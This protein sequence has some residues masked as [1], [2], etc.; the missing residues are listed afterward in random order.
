MDD[1]RE[2]R[3][4]SLLP[5]TVRMVKADDLYIS[6]ANRRRCDGGAVDYY[7]VIGVS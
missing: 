4:Y 7:A 5:I 6:P 1:Y 2:Y 3:V